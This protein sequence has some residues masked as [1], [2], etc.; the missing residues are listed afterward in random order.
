MTSKIIGICSAQGG[1]GRTTLAINVASALA[2]FSR[3]V[4]LLDL[5]L[6]KPHVH[7]Y[8]GY[9]TPAKTIQDV[10][11]GRAHVSDTLVTHAS[12][13]RV[14]LGGKLDSAD[15]LIVTED[16]VNRV[17]A[18]LLGSASIILVDMPGMHEREFSSVCSCMDYILVVTGTTPV[19]LHDTK[20]LLDQLT[21]Q[22]VLGVVSVQGRK[23]F[24]S[25]AQIQA[26]VET[27]LI[28]NIVYDELV[29][30][31]EQR[32]YPVVSL[33]PESH[34]SQSYKALAANLLGEKYTI[35]PLPVVPF[36]K[37]YFM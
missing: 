22:R 18:D 25:P 37:S 24:F 3:S 5:H 2:S 10:F 23:Q 9:L 15:T 32:M 34:A 16:S 13:L 27:P 28:G 33:H 6:Q 8:L 7:L 21:T 26:Y 4:L 31:S 11:F 1:V 17:L 20:S 29:L 14:S 30:Q 12:G 19:A 35:T 36:I